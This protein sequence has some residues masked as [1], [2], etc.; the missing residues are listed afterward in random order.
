MNRRKFFL[1]LAGALGLFLSG[2]G[3]AWANKA[4]AKIEA[5]E[6]APKGSEIVIRVTVIHN[7][8]NFFHHVEWLWIQFNDKEVARWDYTASNRPE[9]ET[10][11]KEIKYKVEGSVD[12]KAKASCN[13]HGSAGEAVAKVSIK[14]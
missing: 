4:E 8:N 5:P 9:G 14:E 3:I 7:A 12:I 6:S 11:T 1:A 2:R 10:F 13:L